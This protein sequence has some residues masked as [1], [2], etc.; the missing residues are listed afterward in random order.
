MP[1][2]RSE[3]PPLVKIIHPDVIFEGLIGKIKRNNNRSSPFGV[4]ALNWLETLHSVCRELFEAGSK[5]FSKRN[6]SHHCS[7]CG[8]PILTDHSIYKPRHRQLINSWAAFAGGTTRDK[9]TSV[10]KDSVTKRSLE[11]VE[12]VPSVHPDKTLADLVNKMLTN[13]NSKDP[14]ILNAVQRLKILHTVCMKQYEIGSRDFSMRG[15]GAI[16]GPLGGPTFR[17][18]SIYRSTNRALVEAWAVFANGYTRTPPQILRE[19]DR[20][21]TLDYIE[22]YFQRTN[23]LPSYEM[24]HAEGMKEF[25]GPGKSLS[26]MNNRVTSSMQLWSQSWTQQVPADVITACNQLFETLKRIPTVPEV[27]DVLRVGDLEVANDLKAKIERW[28][29]YRFA[30]ELWSFAPTNDKT[31][32]FWLALHPELAQWRELVVGYLNFQP[33]HRKNLHLALHT[34]FVRY[35]LASGAKLTPQAFLAYGYGPPDFFK[36]SSKERGTAGSK[37][38]CVAINGFVE[39]VLDRGKDFVEIDNHGHRIRKAQ[40][41]NNFSTAKSEAAAGRSKNPVNR[42]VAVGALQDPELNYLVRANPNFEEWRV[43][44]ISWLASMKLNL[45]A[46]QTAIREIFIDYISAERLPADPSILLSAEWQRN[47]PLPL[48]RETALSTVG[49]RH[50]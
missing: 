49:S 44:A 46:A 45:G 47:N 28:R 13:R 33:E 6:V 5:D 3:S 42:R 25:L 32:F 27:E 2:Q 37:K 19:Q 8:G 26:S 20:R 16:S 7:S 18:K 30:M 36:F 12:A 48:Y 11:I 10:K 50:A 43:Y 38:E 24:I 22:N 29:K 9:N 34:F 40:Y 41:R 35:L 15:L 23:L 14:I 31:E 17:D 4:R 21:E 39:Y 1:R